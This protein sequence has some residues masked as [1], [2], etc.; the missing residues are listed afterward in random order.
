M[1][2]MNKI[3]LKTAALTSVAIISLIIIVFSVFALFF[4]IKISDLCF[5]LGLNKGYVFFAE[6]AY[7]KDNSIDN[8]TTVW[9]RAVYA[10]DYAAV[11]KYSKLLVKHE[12]FEKLNEVYSDKYI[13]FD[14]KA[15]IYANYALSEYILNGI[16][17]ALSIAESGYSPPYNEYNSFSGIIARCLEMKNSSD[18]GKIAGKLTEIS[19][20]DFK[21]EIEI[22]SKLTIDK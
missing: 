4:P 17:S 21:D 5:E 13:S 15:Y 10:D 20:T 9:D 19:E 16:E 6:K 7:E 3:I 2:K 12:D 18:A 1:N 22:L 14:Y 8:L 11:N